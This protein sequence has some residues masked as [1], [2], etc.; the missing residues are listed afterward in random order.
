ML[1]A[2]GMASLPMFFRHIPDPRRAQGKRH[3]LETVLAISAAAI[4]CRIRGYSAI[5]DWVKDLSQRARERFSC[6]KQNGRFVVPSQYIIRNVLIRIDPDALDRAL[7]RWNESY[8][9]EDSSLAIDGKAM[10]NAVDSDGDQTHIMSAMGHQSKACYNIP[11]IE[12]KDHKETHEVAYGITSRTSYQDP[13]SSY[14][15]G[16]AHHQPQSLNH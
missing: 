12:K 6:R 5:P 1:R 10:K 13:I 7:Q 11:D 15:P 4:L 14:S 3:S 9:I 8:G 16:S 2:A